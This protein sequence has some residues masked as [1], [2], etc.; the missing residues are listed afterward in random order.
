MS[1]VETAG[2]GASARPAQSL[3]V[4]P[5]ADC[6]DLGVPQIG[7]KAASLARLVRAGFRVPD[8]VVLTTAFF[9]SWWEELHATADW[10]RFEQA[11]QVDPARQSFQQS[12]QP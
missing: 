3:A 12:F 7:G 9:A 11:E 2:S 4:V 1:S 5:L 6:H 8:A 10:A